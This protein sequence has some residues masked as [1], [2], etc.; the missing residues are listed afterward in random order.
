[1]FSPS[2]D[3]A[4][5]FLTD[6][7]RKGRA[8]EPLSALERMAS[9]VIALH[10]EYH[11]MIEQPEAFAGRDFRPESGD[12]NPFLHLQ[13]HL[14]VEEQLSIDQPFGIRRLFEQLR[15]RLGDDH[16]ASHAVLECLAEVLWQSQRTATGPDAELYLRLLGER[17]HD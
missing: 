14:A 1:M 4:R 17:L 6:A 5:A 8:G 12:M 16:A 3:Q 2:R 15:E 7:W 10:P 13:L 9:G 11:S